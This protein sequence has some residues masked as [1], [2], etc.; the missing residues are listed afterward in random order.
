[1]MHKGM[2]G[3]MGH[4]FIIIYLKVWN[5]QHITSVTAHLIK[6]TTLAPG[7]WR[8]VSVGLK[9]SFFPKPD[10][11]IGSTFYHSIWGTSDG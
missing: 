6:D 9:Y 3:G 5:V 8:S 4:H 1:M 10:N 7:K 11:M 2:Q